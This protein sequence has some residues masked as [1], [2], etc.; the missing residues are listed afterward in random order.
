MHVSTTF[1]TYCTTLPELRWELFRSRNLEGEML[2]PTLG[3]LLPH[4]TRANFMAMRDKSYTTSCPDLPPIKK[5]GW[6]EHEG[7]YITV[8]CLS[9]PAPQAVIELTKCGCK[10]D[11]KGRCSCFKN[12]LPCTPLFK[13]FGK[14]CANPF[15]SDT[16]VDYEEEDC[17][18]LNA[19]KLKSHFKKPVSFLNEKSKRVHAFNKRV[20]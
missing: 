7:A 15:K 6:S 19:R 14:N 8:K 1:D 9:L 10:S 3:S 16:R 5:N 13:C 17:D 18:A 4:I 11:C 2:P 20:K 12:G